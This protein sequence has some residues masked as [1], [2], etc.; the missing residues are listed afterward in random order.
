MGLKTI[1]EY[2]ENDA[3]AEQLTRMGV[4]YLQGYGIDRP[5][6]LTGYLESLHTGGSRRCIQ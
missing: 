4:D 2:V 1:A 5:S 3:I 6:P